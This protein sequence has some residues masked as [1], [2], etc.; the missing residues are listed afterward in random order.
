MIPPITE[1]SEGSRMSE[2]YQPSGTRF[3]D[4]ASG[5]EMMLVHAGELYAG[6]IVYKHPDGQWVTLRE[7]T[8]AD[9]RAIDAA[10]IAAHHSHRVE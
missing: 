2:I 3:H 4:L 5:R 6:W 10:V 1:P 9:R 8:D 7:A